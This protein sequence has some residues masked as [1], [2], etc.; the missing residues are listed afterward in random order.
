MAPGWSNIGVT[1]LIA[2]GTGKIAGGGIFTI[3]VVR[4]LAPA[5]TLVRQAWTRAEPHLRAKSPGWGQ[6]VHGGSV[7][8]CFGIY[9]LF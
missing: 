9:Y 2:S 8:I 1:M 3:L 7:M 5:V 4:M 6:W